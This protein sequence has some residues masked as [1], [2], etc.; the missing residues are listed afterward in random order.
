MQHAL[1]IPDG[2]APEAPTP[3]ADPTC[4]VF[5]GVAFDVQAGPG[6]QWALT[7]EHRLFTSGYLQEPVFA[8]V[9][10]A[11]TASTELGFEQHRE[12][13]GAWDGDVAMVRTSRA[14]AEIRD[15]GTSFVA[16]A[17]VAPD[18][19]GCS[20]LCT[21]V[22]AL[23]AE[24]RGG[25]ILHATGVDLD[26]EG[27]LFIGP[28]GAGKTTAANHCASG[29][30]FARDRAIVFPVGPAWFS[31]AL[32][33]GGDCALARSS[34]SVL[35]LRAIYR[36]RQAVGAPRVEEVALGDRLAV[37]RECQQAT[38]ATVPGE[39]ARIDALLHL[40]STLEVASI[41]TVLGAPLEA[42][43]GLGAH[44]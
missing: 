8:R 29:R 41:R 21:A 26:G 13:V 1:T 35:R 14:R 23:I 32:P 12:V 6:V 30:W 40:A 5:G 20:N 4:F 9:H 31:S 22:L 11:V 16:T 38:M 36:V 33:G 27:V 18:A 3:D 34:R 24:R 28:S 42:A 7:D 19:N 43:L 2:P 44:R 10:L 39:R 17:R 25:V 37:L 15:L